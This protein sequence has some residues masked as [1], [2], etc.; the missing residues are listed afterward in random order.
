M[1]LAH[2]IN[3]DSKKPSCDPPISQL[4]S[5]S[6]NRKFK[7]KVE[8]TAPLKN[9]HVSGTSRKDMS[10]LCLRSVMLVQNNVFTVYMLEAST[11]FH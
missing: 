11:L 8:D 10:V 5:G 4:L 1:R 9:V 3:W 7:T 2:G 6:T